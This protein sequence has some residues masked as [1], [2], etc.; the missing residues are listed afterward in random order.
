M[1]LKSLK[2]KSEQGNIKNKRLTAVGQP[3]KIIINY[4]ITTEFNKDDILMFS[5]L[6]VEQENFVHLH[7]LQEF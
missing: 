2:H 3:I 5:G 1:F 4:R 7:N 6:Y